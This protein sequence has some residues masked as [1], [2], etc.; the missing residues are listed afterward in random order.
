MN[1]KATD[2]CGN[3]GQE[4]AE[5]NYVKDSITEYECPIPHV[6]SGYGFFCGGDPRN[7]HP[8]HESCTPEEIERHRL[9]CSEAERLDSARD[10]P[11]PS[12]WIRT[13]SGMAHVVNAP[14]GIGIYTIEMP[15]F[16]EA[17]D[18]AESIEA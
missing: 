2:R 3:C 9:A 4:F 5:H 7:F 13:K 10:L 8:D 16:F 11:C 17:A 1:V 6:E 14:F 18:D 12:G 15:Q